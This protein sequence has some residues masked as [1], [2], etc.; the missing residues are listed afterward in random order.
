MVDGFGSFSW[1]S[2]T[3]DKIPQVSF[4]FRWS[5]RDLPV[6]KIQEYGILTIFQHFFI[7]FSLFKLKFPFPAMYVSARAGALG[8]SDSR[9][10][11]Q[12]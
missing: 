4:R 10:F 12:F 8:C 9:L 3:A 11:L 6:A 5:P 7:N 2:K 1:S